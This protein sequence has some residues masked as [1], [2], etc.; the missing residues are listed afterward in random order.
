[1]MFSILHTS[2]LIL[3]VYHNLDI[4]S[5]TFLIRSPFTSS[6]FILCQTQVNALV[7]SRL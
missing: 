1:L 4:V 2:I 3:H 5:L 6:I 7:A